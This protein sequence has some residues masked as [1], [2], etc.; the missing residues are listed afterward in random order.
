MT[1]TAPTASPS[2]DLIRHTVWPFIAAIVLTILIW[3]ATGA[4]LGLFLGALFL[5]AVL[6]PPIVLLGDQRIARLIYAGAITDGVGIVWLA[7]CFSGAISF[8]E[9]IGAYLI[10]V[11]F[12]ILLAGLVS[13]LARLRIH[14]IFT[15]AITITVAL[16]WITWPVW[17]SAILRDSASQSLV[18]ALV[19]L[20]PALAI[21]GI[22]IHFGPWSQ[23][24]IAY[25]LT[26]LGQNIAYVLPVHGIV[27]IVVH[28]AL[29]AILFAIPVRRADFNP[30]VITQVD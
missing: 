25:H 5:V 4:S 8:R 28:V 2:S 15:A 19:Q 10:L 18:N 6:L 7:A 21:N 12:G 1:E 13:G 17:L 14:P 26:D 24:S 20:N 22:L 3:L 16:L 29:G 23:A 27:C 11:A 9:W 30:S